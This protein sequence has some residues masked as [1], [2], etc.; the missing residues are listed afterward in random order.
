MGGGLATKTRADIAAAA[1]K[2]ARPLA[3]LRGAMLQR[4][5]DV[6]KSAAPV[7]GGRK[8]GQVTGM[9]GSKDILSRTSI[10]HIHDATLA[11]LVDRLPTE[12]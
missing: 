9:R 2:Q 11:Q 7:R 5:V 1:G 6:L 12:T 3:G 4:G 10:G 8:H